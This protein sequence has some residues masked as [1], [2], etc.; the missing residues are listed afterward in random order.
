VSNVEVIENLPFDRYV[1]IDRV[2]ISSLCWLLDSPH[3]YAYQSGEVDDDT[4]ALRVGRASHTATLEPGLYKDVAV[5][6]GSKKDESGCTLKAFVA[7]HAAD[8]AT[9]LSS[10]QDEQARGVAAA[11]HTHPIASKLFEGGQK[12]LTVLWTHERTGLRMKARLD[13]LNQALRL[14]VDLKTAARINPGDFARDAAKFNYDIKMSFYGE[15]ALQVMGPGELATSIVAV[16]SKQPHD[17]QC[18]DLGDI[19]DDYLAK[20]RE[21]YEALIDLLIKCREKN[22]WP[23][24]GAA[25]VLQLTR[26]AYI[27]RDVEAIR[28]MGDF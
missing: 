14:L 18:Y 26:P 11:V 2:N 20:G 3:N 22:Y 1:A 23:G 21:V 27:Q 25:E 15:A 7:K 13:Y 10:I 12:E 17:V 4:N 9:A 5:W 28:A 8:G 19:D 16:E 24:R 6:L